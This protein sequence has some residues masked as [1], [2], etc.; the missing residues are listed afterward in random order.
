MLMKLNELPPQFKTWY[1][2]YQSMKNTN[3]FGAYKQGAP[4][5]ICYTPGP[6]D[7]DP[8]FLEIMHLAHIKYKI[9]PEFANARIVEEFDD[10]LSRVNDDM[11]SKM[12]YMARTLNM[13]NTED[14][15]GLITKLK[16]FVNK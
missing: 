10:I 1:Q 4:K 2:F 6:E 14:V 8:N 13:P 12:D 9:H 5:R 3:G 7:A 16:T 15:Y 11:L